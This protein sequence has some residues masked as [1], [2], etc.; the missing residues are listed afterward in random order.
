MLR[1]AGAE[2]GKALIVNTASVA[3]K[4]GQPWLSVY[5][6][7][8]AAVVGFSQST[9]KEI[10]NDGIQVTALCPGF[11]DTPMTDFVK[12]S[13]D[14]DAMIR[15]IRHRRVGAVPAADLVGLP[16]ARD[17]LPAPRRGAL[18]RCLAAFAQRPAGAAL[19][20]PGRAEKLGGS[21]LGELLVRGDDEVLGTGRP[22]P[23][24]AH[25]AGDADLRTRPVPPPVA[26]VPRN[27]RARRP[28]CGRRPRRARR[29][30]G[31]PRRRSDPLVAGVS[32]RLSSRKDRRVRT[33][34]PVARRGRRA[35][36]KASQAIA[37]EA[38]SVRPPLRWAASIGQMP[39]ERRVGVGADDDRVAL[40]AEQ[41]RLA[42]A[43]G[44][45]VDRRAQALRG[46]AVPRPHRGQDC[47][48]MRPFL[49]DRLP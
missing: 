18:G 24:H 41:H 8:K 39:P 48:A 42:G 9:Q 2:H 43:L 7:T 35:S 11:V 15:P 1:E 13:V 23:G 3:G 38:R 46:I 12:E 36:V 27:R 40:D 4:S 33:S 25:A 47:A 16:G 14:A 28:R 26:R 21:L 37:K 10:Q 19:V 22:V 17:R 20:A 49:G 31:L 29:G 44:Q 34:R 32:R 45:P 6:A 5:S 30:C